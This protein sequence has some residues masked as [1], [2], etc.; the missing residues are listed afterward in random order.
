MAEQ[1]Q[2]S[3]TKGQ[4]M[5]QPLAAFI[6]DNG[7]SN[8]TIAK[9]IKQFFEDRDT[10]VYA[11]IVSDSEF[12]KW[13]SMITEGKTRIEKNCRGK[14]IKVYKQAS[15]QNL[16]KE[17]KKESVEAVIKGLVETNDTAE[18]IN[19][20]LCEMVGNYWSVYKT[21]DDVSVSCTYNKY[22]VSHKGWTVWR[23]GM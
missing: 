3:L 7:E 13:S 9:K 16:L 10:G 23:H 19:N 15:S 22:Y 1:K 2:Q 21:R 14:F 17:Y 12:F 8:Y 11:A 18:T 20:I 4:F 5:S 6:N